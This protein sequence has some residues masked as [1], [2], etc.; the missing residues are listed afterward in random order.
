MELPK[1]TYESVP[2]AETTT[3]IDIYVPEEKEIYIPEEE[4]Y[5][6]ELATQKEIELIALVTMAEAEGECEDGKRLVI[7]TIL[8][9]V[10]SEH[11]PDTI[12]DVIFQ[13]NQFTSMWSSRVKRCE[14]REDICQLVREELENR[15]NYDVIFFRTN[16][17]SRYGTPL[18][19]L[20]NHYF[21]SY[22]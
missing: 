4:A 2:V 9:R 18:F 19:K 8:N 1:T 13:P 20:Q 7:D 12:H 15:T 14:V 6:Q 11:F 22:A 5:E 21:S 17:Y 16:R 3:T 10:D